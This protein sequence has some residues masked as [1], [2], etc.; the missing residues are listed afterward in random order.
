[1]YYIKFNDDKHELNSNTELKQDRIILSSDKNK[2]TQVKI[3]DSATKQY[4]ILDEND[5]VINSININEIKKYISGESTKIEEKKEETVDESEE[6]FI[7]EDRESIYYGNRVY[8]SLTELTG[9]RSNY[10]I[11]KDEVNLTSS[12]DNL[13]NSLSSLRYA[14]VKSIKYKIISITKDSD[15]ANIELADDFKDGKYFELYTSSGKDDSKLEGS[16]AYKISPAVTTPTGPVTV[17]LKLHIEVEYFTPNI[18][19]NTMITSS[20]FSNTNWT[21]MNDDNYVITYLDNSID[22]DKFFDKSTDKRIYANFV[23][24]TRHN[25]NDK[26]YFVKPTEYPTKCIFDNTNG[27]NSYNPMSF[28]STENTDVDLFLYLVQD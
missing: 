8:L 13:G 12:T 9:D 27:D 1:M 17:T 16:I 7:I 3:I 14:G 26:V 28:Y 11:L 6:N 18:K 4:S 2:I 22:W 19:I 10:R 21:D 15:E 23:Y 5:E 20:E 25:D 24:A